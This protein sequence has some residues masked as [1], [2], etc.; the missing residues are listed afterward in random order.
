MAVP[1]ALS[2]GVSRAA[3]SGI[4]FRDVEAIEKASRVDV[5]FLDKTGTLTEGRLRL[6]GCE[7]ASGVSEHDLLLDAA[8]AEA[9]SEHPIAKAICA[10]AAGSTVSRGQA[11]HE[12]V[13][14]STRAVPGYGVEWTSDSGVS[15]LA[16]RR[17]WLLERGV[18][19]PDVTRAFTSVHV[20]RNGQWRGVLYLCDT[21]RDG[22]ADALRHMAAR[23]L[24][25]AMLTGDQMAVALDIAEAVGIGH[26]P[27][28]ASESPESKAARIV[29]AQASGKCAG[30]IGDGLNDG[31][32]LA[33]ADFSV[34][35]GSASPSSIAAASI[36]LVDSG[37]E[38][39]NTALM[40][41]TRTQ[42][43]MRQNLVAAGIYNLLAIPL[44]VSGF[45][46][47]GFAAALMIL[48]SL[49]VTLNASRLMVARADDTRRSLCEQV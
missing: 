43:A 22:A 25:L 30:F 35:V 45:V 38:K 26:C 37:I 34:A 21:P 16:G 17:E 14:G 11:A 13:C 49:S 15:V 40:L 10:V 12:A 3:R 4:L 1:L 36:V 5:F 42:A 2:A 47:P 39:L 41:A 32:A 28:F 7:V 20:A 33:A 19:V 9:G 44:A 31:P 23:G 29:G 18:A 27:V 48:S 46:S 6:A 24:G 8:L